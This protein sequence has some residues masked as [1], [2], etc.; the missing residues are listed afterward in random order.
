MEIYRDAGGGLGL[1]V[2]GG[3]EHRIPALISRIV[4]GQA[5]AHT[6]QLF[7]GDAILKVTLEQYP[8][9]GCNIG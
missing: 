3:A 4:P 5:A 1:S 6:E 2:K 8:C 9:T 7:I